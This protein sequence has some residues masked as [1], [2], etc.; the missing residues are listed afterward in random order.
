L[1]REARLQ[2]GG[3]MTAGESGAPGSP[4]RGGVT[5]LAFYLPQFHEIPENN[6]WWGEGF[7]EWTHLR[8]ARQWTR[9]QVIR[10]P[11]PPLGEYRLTDGSVMELQW[12]LA[13]AHGIDGFAVWDYWFGGGRQL[14]ERPI[15]MVRRD[16]LRFRYC[17]AWANHSWFDKARDRLLCEQRY[18]GREDYE[19]YVDRACSHFESVN[20]VKIDD[21]PVLM[22][23]DAHAIPDWHVFCETCRSRAARHGFPDI[24]LCAD[25]IVEGDPYI[26]QVDKYSDSFRFLTR[27]N[28]LVVNYVKENLKRQFD[29]ELGPRRFDFRR[30]ER[31]IVPAT[32]S[33]KFAPTILTGWDTTPRHG[34]GGAIFEHLDV[35]SLERQLGSAAAHFARFP[36]AG[37]LLLLKSWNEWAEGNILEPDDVYGDAMLKAIRSFLDRAPWQ[38]HEQPSDVAA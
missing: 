23:F 9:G 14:L 26:E 27:R 1:A 19:R 36:R 28:R 20:Y 3:F 25:R 29:I 13:E 7:T 10:R 32:A 31:D 21:K 2:A 37:H 30:L 38:R 8:R 12:R 22:V 35:S 5:T 6:A 4:G 33:A 18:L 17:L 15:E 34:R 24:F 11:V 16:R